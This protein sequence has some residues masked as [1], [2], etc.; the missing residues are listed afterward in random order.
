MRLAVPLA[1][2][3]TPLPSN[4]R[5]G[6]VL[7]DQ[8]LNEIIATGYTL[9]LPGNTHAEQ[10]CLLKL[11]AHNISEEAIGENI[12]DKAVI[13][14]TMKPLSILATLTCFINHAV[15]I[16]LPNTAPPGPTS[17]FLTNAPT[18]IPKNTPNRLNLASLTPR[19]DGSRITWHND[20]YGSQ[21]WILINRGTLLPE[22]H[23]RAVIDGAFNQLLFL[24]SGVLPI[25]ACTG[26][27]C[28]SVGQ[29]G[30]ALHIRS[31]NNHQVTKGV[32]NSALQEL[33]DYMEEKGA[34]G[35]VRVS[36]FDGRNQVGVL[37]IGW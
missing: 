20:I 36:I 28:H 3:P 35:E 12:P 9:K 13:Y 11:A 37:T 4:F 33:V 24:G 14:T 7:V 17:Q 1:H 15:S 30:L 27:M 2:K 5:V 22:A 8:E 18:L 25:D 29:D 26:W 19:D 16:P 32:L 10:C 23:V 34:W 6:A 31:S 21:T